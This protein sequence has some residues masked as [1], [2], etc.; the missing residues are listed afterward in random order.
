[1]VAQVEETTAPQPLFASIAIKC[2]VTPLR[3]RSPSQAVSMEK[4][5]AHLQMRCNAASRKP[6]RTV[7]VQPKIIF[8]GSKTEQR[9]LRFPVVSETCNYQP[10]VRARE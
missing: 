9:G 8:A 3:G 10:N 6:H 7:V 2:F 5:T 1:M 4:T